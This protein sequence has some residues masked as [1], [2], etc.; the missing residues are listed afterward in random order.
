MSETARSRRAASKTSSSKTSSSKTSTPDVTDNPEPGQPR[1]PKKLGGKSLSRAS[2]VANSD[3]GRRQSSKS[4]PDTDSA[5][6]QGL[7]HLKFYSSEL[8]PGLRI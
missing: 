8:A 4:R 1:S 3:K 2:L 6:D 5:L 7:M